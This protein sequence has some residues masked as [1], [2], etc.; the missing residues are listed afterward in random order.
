MTTNG[1]ALCPNAA[2]DAVTATTAQA[3]QV[4]HEPFIT[5]FP[6]AQ[7]SA[8]RGRPTATPPCAS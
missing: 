3:T 5:A 4:C 6:H 8:G 7:N 2:Q 1:C